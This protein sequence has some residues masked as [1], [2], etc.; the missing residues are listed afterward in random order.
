MTRPLRTREG[1]FLL[2]GLL[3]GV[4]LVLAISGSPIVFTIVLLVASAAVLAAGVAREVLAFLSPETDG[5]RDH[6]SAGAETEGNPEA[7]SNGENVN[8]TQ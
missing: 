3:A 6:T 7:R 2:A 5:S 1:V 4:G 8:R